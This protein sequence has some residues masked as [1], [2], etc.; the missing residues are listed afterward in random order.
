MYQL[1]DYPPL[2]L[3]VLPWEGARAYFTTRWGGVS[4]GP[5]AGLNLGGTVGDQPANVEANWRQLKE[6]LGLRDLAHISC[7]QVHGDRVQVVETDHLPPPDQRKIFPATD[8]LV[9]NLP[10]VLLTSLYAD[11]VPLVFFDPQRKVI[12]MA[13]AGWRGTKAGIGLKTLELMGETFGTEPRHCLVGIGPSIGPCCYR[14]GEEVARGFP[15][16]TIQRREDGYY[17]DLWRANRTP[18][19]EAGILPK[20]LAKAELCTCCRSSLFYSHRASQ[21]RGGRMASLILLT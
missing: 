18:L 8:G 6:T 5:L 16:E 21:G 7:E 2:K 15:A 13:H 9:T 4:Q 1:R 3:Y 17:L 19:I 20:N 11:C 10:G 14:V 12:G